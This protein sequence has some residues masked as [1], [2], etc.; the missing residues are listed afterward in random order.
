MII[1]TRRIYRCFRPTPDGKR[2]LFAGRSSDPRLGPQHNGEN[3]RKQMVDLFP[4]LANTE[5]SHSWG[6][7]VRF[8][9]DYLPHLG[10]LDGVHYAM[11]LNAA[12]A[13]MAPYLGNPIAL[14]ML[15]QRDDDGLL[16]RFEFRS[17]PFYSGEPWFLPFVLALYRLL[18]KLGR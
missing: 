6:G 17:R 1:D 2:L 5:L 3:L 16:E 8:T 13:S 10:E 11:G 7:Y 18:D 15:G 14:R 4:M 9:F 12:G